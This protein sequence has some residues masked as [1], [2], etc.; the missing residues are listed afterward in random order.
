MLKLLLASPGSAADALCIAL[1]TYRTG[2]T[3]LL[4]KLTVPQLAN[5]SPHFIYPEC[6]LPHSQLPAISP[7]PSLP[8]S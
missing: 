2:N 6:Q 3:L 4:E 7:Y 5:K 8:I 1:Y